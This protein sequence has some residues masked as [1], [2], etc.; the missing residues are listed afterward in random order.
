MSSE[1]TSSYASFTH[2]TL[3]SELPRPRAS[4]TRPLVYFLAN[5][6]STRPGCISSL[7]CPR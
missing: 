1:Q 4:T 5:I 3:P 6:G 2:P 7:T